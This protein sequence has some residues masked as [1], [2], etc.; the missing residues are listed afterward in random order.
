MTSIRRTSLATLGGLLVCTFAI[1]SSP[2]S[3]VGA[4]PSDSVA[5]VAIV[6]EGQGYGHGRG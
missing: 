2:I 5:G 4:T 1:V 3:P 6:I